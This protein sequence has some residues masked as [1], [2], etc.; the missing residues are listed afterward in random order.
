[1]KSGDFVGFPVGGPPG[2]LAVGTPNVYGPSIA[3]S[4]TSTKP[5]GLGQAPDFLVAY[6]ENVITEGGYAAGD[7]IYIQSHF[8]NVT[9]GVAVA[10]DNINTTITV[11]NT[12]LASLINRAS[13]A[14]FTPTGADWRIVA[15]P[16]RVN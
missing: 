4:G 11:N 13:G 1:M 5:H 15:V 3:T 6:F 12:S 7:R 9:S 14:V 10:A 8:D 16:Y 2:T